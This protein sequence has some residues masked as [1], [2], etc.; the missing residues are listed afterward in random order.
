[1]NKASIV[2]QGVTGEIDLGEE[3]TFKTGSRGY[4]NASKLTVGGK[5]YQINILAIECGS[6]PAAS[7]TAAS[8]TPAHKGK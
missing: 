3:R 4:Q 5:K 8:V 2:I 1:M 7:V 6:K